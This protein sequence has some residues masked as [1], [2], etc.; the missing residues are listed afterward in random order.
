MATQTVNLEGT[1][2]V[3][4]ISSIYYEATS[5]ANNYLYGAER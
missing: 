3:S 4:D 5:N 2:Y 1:Q